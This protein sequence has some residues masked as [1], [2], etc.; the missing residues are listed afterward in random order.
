MLSALNRRIYRIPVV[1]TGH[2]LGTLFVR[3]FTAP[4]LPR[5]FA[6]TFA[7][8]DDDMATPDAK[9]PKAPAVTL[10]TPK[11]TRD[12]SGQDMLLREEVFKMITDVFKK[13]GGTPLDTP[14]FELKEILA[15]KYGEDSK[16]IYDLQDQ[17]GELCSLR[18]DLTVPFARWLAMN[19]IQAVKRYHIAK[20]YR[21]DQPAIAR[22]RYR[23]FHQCDFDI[24]GVYDP[25]IPDAEVLR[26]IVEVFEALQL[27]VTIKLNHR[28]V[29]DGMFAVAGVTP[30]KIRTISS[31]VDKLDKMSWED[32][33]KE[34]VEEK[35]LANEV[36]DRIG[37]YVR[38]A[39]TI[40]ETLK[41]LKS[42]EE[43][44][45]NEQV[46]RGLDDM[47]LLASYVEAFGIADKIS[48][49]LSLARGLDYYTGLIYEVINLPPKAEEGQ[50]SG[51]KS[52]KDDPASQV[53]SIAAGGR[54]DNLV[55]MYGKRQIPC[56]G[57]SFGVDRIFTILEAR[58][59][60]DGIKQRRDVDVY[61]MAFGDKSS[62]GLLL[63]RMSVAQRL[64]SAGIRAEF[65]PKVKPKLPQQFKAAEGVPLGVILGQ[66]ELDAGQ[67]RVKVLGQG[68]N[69]EDDKPAE[70][71][72]G[73]LVSLD[74]LADEVKKLLV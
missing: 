56:V 63:E 13:H 17:G 28:Q 32:V 45:A 73:K 2:P 60:K 69:K 5:Q 10:K 68:E 27:G 46:K 16:L 3:S 36:A 26:I 65:S 15:G 14:V 53:G 41:L 74:Q 48:F 35:G 12:W 62:N 11:G 20:V 37:E 8:D 7:H 24:A 50:G 44:V 6:A 47:T 70:K 54:Y 33:K 42:R 40:S 58:R 4:S 43:L 23:E 72:N 19:N 29:L 64:W 49:D 22:G 18:Y 61:V 57:I 67:V 25:M 59:R 39:G 51:K 52:K 55:G 21:R 31:A 30:E 9:V 34:M 38:H 71:D 66:T 1:R